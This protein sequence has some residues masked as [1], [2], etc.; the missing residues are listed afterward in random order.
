[1]RPAC[2][3]F[4]VRLS[5]VGNDRYLQLPDTVTPETIALAAELIDRL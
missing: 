1:M 5:T 2:A 3:A 4:V